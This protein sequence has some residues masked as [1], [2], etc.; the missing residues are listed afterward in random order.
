MPDQKRISE[1]N[2]FMNSKDAQFFTKARKRKAPYP[3]GRDE[4]GRLLLPHFKKN[5]EKQH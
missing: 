2:S 1:N 5:T 3:L 4:Y